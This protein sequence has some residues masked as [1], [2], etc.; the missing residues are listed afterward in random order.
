M[1]E[2]C[3]EMALFEDFPRRAVLEDCFFEKANALENHGIYFL[4]ILLSNA[5]AEQNTA[6]HTVSWPSS[7]NY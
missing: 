7:K 3:P 4:C 6:I 2:D 5:E 1:L